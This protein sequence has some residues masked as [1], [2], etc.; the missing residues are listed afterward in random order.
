MVPVLFALMDIIHHMPDQMNVKYVRKVIFVQD[1]IKSLFHAILVK[2]HLVKDIHS[3]LYVL[4]A[5]I[6][7]LVVGQSVYAV[8]KDINVQELIKHQFLVLLEL[9]QQVV[10]LFVQNVRM[11]IIQHILIPLDVMHVHLVTH[12]PIQHCVP[13]HVW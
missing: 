2:Y 6:R 3:V 4:L 7:Q 11:A 12:V 10:K 8:L 5:L 1:E 13:N 9:I